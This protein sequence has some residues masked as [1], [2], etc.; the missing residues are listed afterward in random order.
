MK[1]DHSTPEQLRQAVRE[2]YRTAK[3]IEAI[4]L[5]R[6]LLNQGLPDAQLRTLFDVPANQL[7][8]VR[9]NLN[10][11]ATLYDAGRSAAGE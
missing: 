2:R 3:G 10:Q 7:A 1:F 9:G 4:R 8:R 6:Y 11:L 5:G